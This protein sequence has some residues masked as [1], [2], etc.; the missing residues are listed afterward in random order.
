[1]APNMISLKTWIQAKIIF[2]NFLEIYNQISVNKEGVKLQAYVTL[3]ILCKSLNK[4]Q[5]LTKHI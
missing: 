2:R 3:H 4:K 5:N 1:M